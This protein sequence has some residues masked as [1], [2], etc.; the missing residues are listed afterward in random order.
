MQLP[1]PGVDLPQGMQKQANQLWEFLDDMAARDPKEYAEFLR[2][3]MEGQQ[4]A[5]KQRRQAETPAAGF[6]VRTRLRSQQPLYINVCGHSRIQPPSRC[7]RRHSVSP[8]RRAT[9]RLLRAPAPHRL[10]NR[11]RAARPTGPCRSRSACRDRR[12]APRA[13]GSPSTSSSIPR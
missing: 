13:T 1:L 4:A 9:A 2:K 10:T 3:Q 7:A 6:C 12:S 5:T 8:A 11:V